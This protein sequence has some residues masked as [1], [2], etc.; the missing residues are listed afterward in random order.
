MHVVTFNPA[1]ERPGGCFSCCYFGHR[2]DVA[3]WCGKPGQGHVR[4]QAERGCA[5]WQ[6]EAGA[7]D[8]LVTIRS[9]EGL[10]SEVEQNYHEYQESK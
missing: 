9:T 10:S 2:V 1:V 6:R 3:V 8:D 4:S 5:F 7:D